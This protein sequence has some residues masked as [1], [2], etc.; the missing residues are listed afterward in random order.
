VAEARPDLATARYD[1]G[2]AGGEGS[3]GISS[4]FRFPRP[5]AS[6]KR[7]TG[8]SAIGPMIKVVADLHQFGASS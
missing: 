1:K 2:S 5:F 8:S 6:P 7:C 3:F 4:P